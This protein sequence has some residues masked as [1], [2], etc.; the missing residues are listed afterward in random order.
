MKNKQ[1]PIMWNPWNKVVQD[2][3]DGT[4]HLAQ[5]NKERKRRGLPTP[6]VPSMGEYD[7]RQKPSY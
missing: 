2:H 6:W 1:N 5:T 3:R 7:T 4:I